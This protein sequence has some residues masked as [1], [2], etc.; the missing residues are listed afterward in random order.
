MP[1]TRDVPG[2]ARQSCSCGQL[3][4]SELLARR[5]RAHGF[6]KVFRTRRSTPGSMLAHGHPL[7]G[8]RVGTR[9]DRGFPQVEPKVGIE[10]TAY[11][12]PRR[13][14]TTE[15]LGLAPP[16]VTSTPAALGE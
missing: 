15:L 7:K 11:A 2:V 3:E 5:C 6:D 10:P 16:M 13:C 4:A 1:P 9:W 8:L 14:S 12:L